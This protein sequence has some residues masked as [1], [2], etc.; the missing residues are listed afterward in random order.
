MTSS[1]LL[2]PPTAEA[3]SVVVALRVDIA[4]W[5]RA[6]GD[7]EYGAL[8]SA[9]D[10]AARAAL[11]VYEPDGVRVVSVHG[12]DLRPPPRGAA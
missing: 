12:V 4:S 5:R 2:G 11:A 1:P 8:T 10:A 7:D 9:V 3:V 6:H